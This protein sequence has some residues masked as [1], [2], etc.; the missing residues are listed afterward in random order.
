VR[1]QLKTN[2]LGTHDKMPPKGKVFCAGCSQE[3]KNKDYL[4]CPQCTNTFDLLCASVP[5]DKY[6]TMNQEQKGKWS[7]Q[8]CMRHKP[9]NNDNNTPVRGLQASAASIV[10]HETERCESVSEKESFVTLRDAQRHGNKGNQLGQLAGRTDKLE[11]GDELLTTKNI[12]SIIKNEI[13]LAI[14]AEMS[15]IRSLIESELAPL[16]SKLD[17]IE[18]S[19]AFNSAQYDD[20]TQ[21]VNSVTQENKKL[22]T[23]CEYLRDTVIDLQARL[24]ATEQHMRNANL[25]I[26]GVPEYRSENVVSVVKQIA[27]VVSCK[28][29]DEDILSCTRVASMNKQSKRPRSIVVKLRSPRCRDELYSSVTK[30]NKTNPKDKLNTSLV[31]IAGDKAPIYVA[32]HLSPAN[33][34]LHASARIRARELGYKYVW[35]RNGQI[36]MRKDDLS[37]FIH[38]KNENTL[39]VLTN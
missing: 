29:A 27:Q 28:V 12:S 9:R 11:Q 21:K 30:Y 5:K 18:A 32:E 24:N 22:Q 20:I 6:R 39:S 23:E 13:R 33:K 8:E 17:A 7:C 15:S 36:F 16:K 10:T 31:G 34:A 35:V 14:K 25:E 1:F 3:I 19:A 26:Q 4:N 38:V 2:T 37:R